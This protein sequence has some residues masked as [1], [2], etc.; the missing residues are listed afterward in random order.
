MSVSHDL[1]L[2][3]NIANMCHYLQVY[4]HC[5]GNDLVQYLIVKEAISVM[6]P[7]DFLDAMFGLKPDGGRSTWDDPEVK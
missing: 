3:E 5:C 1:C 2:P 6:D 7:D 4:Y